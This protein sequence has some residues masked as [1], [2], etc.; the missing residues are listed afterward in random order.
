MKTGCLCVVT[1]KVKV[2][3]G[4]HLRK[5]TVSWCFR[6]HHDVLLQNFPKAFQPVGVSETATVGATR[7]SRKHLVSCTVL[8]GVYGKGCTH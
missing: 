6:L 2:T 5:K 7:T 4:N 3:F 8:R 1:A